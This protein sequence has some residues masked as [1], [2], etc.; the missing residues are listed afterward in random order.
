[1]ICSAFPT[2]SRKISLPSSLSQTTNSNSNDFALLLTFPVLPHV[3]GGR[4]P[5]RVEGVVRVWGALPPPPNRQGRGLKHYRPLPVHSYSRKV[6]VVYVGESVGTLQTFQLLLQKLMVVQ[7]FFNLLCHP[8]V[9]YRGVVHDRVHWRA[10][11][12]VVLDLRVT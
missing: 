3:R 5:R 1:M 8:Q 4:T 2:L 7:L 12:S 9:H 6:W 11:L 10:L